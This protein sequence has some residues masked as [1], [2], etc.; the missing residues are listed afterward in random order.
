VNA[1]PSLVVET[2]V[3]LLVVGSGILSL[4]GAIGLLKLP[5][6]FQRMH[7]PALATTLATWT[8]ALATIVYFSAIGSR[9][10]LYPWLIVVLAAITAPVT[11]A[12]LAR[13]ALFRMRAAGGEAPP[14][15]VTDT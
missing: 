10:A 2:I 8:A 15:I 13:A 6:F 12:L 5:T 14:P 7:P 11:T 3:G 4:V 9:L 1:A